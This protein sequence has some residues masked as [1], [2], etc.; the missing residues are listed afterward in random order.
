MGRSQ[1]LGGSVD[2]GESAA[3]DAGGGDVV[4]LPAASLSPVK[5]GHT[6]A[7]EGQDSS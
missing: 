3:P 2:R 4:A 6:K 1:G 5:G 7:V